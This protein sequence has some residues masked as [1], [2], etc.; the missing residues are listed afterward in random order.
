M[1]ELSSGT[2]RSIHRCLQSKPNQDFC[3]SIIDFFEHYHLPSLSVCVSSDKVSLMLASA[4]ESPGL[5]TSINDWL[6]GAVI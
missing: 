1:E 2:L 5:V 6:E 3:G 4:S